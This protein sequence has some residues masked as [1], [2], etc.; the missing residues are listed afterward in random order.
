[1][2]WFLPMQYTVRFDQY[3][4]S[5]AENPQGLVPNGEGQGRLPQN[6]FVRHQTRGFDI[7][8][9]RKGHHAVDR[10]TYPIWSN[11]I[12]CFDKEHAQFDRYV[13]F[14][15][16]SFTWGYAPFDDNFGTVIERLSNTPILQC[17]VP[18][19][20]QRHQYEKFVEIV[21]HIRNLPKAIFVFYFSNDI[22]D[23]YIHPHSTVIDGWLVDTVSVDEND[24]IVRPTDQEL[25]ATLAD[26]LEQL[27]QKEREKISWWGRVKGGLKTYSL[28]VN[29]LSHAKNKVI[30]M[31]YLLTPS[32][33]TTPPIRNFYA[34]GHQEK[35]GTYWY[36]DNPRAQANKTA[37]LSFKRFSTEK[38]IPFVVVLIPHK[39]K[40]TERWY[41][42]LRAFLAENG[43]R[44]V[45]LTIRFRE[46]G[47]TT[48]DVFWVHDGHLNPSGKAATAEILVDEFPQVFKRSGSTSVTAQ[49]EPSRTAR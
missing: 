8:S 6:Y 2:F 19:T 44:Y 17:G 22:I 1:M 35:N 47:L 38:H 14:A 9:N 30:E 31:T 39:Y 29:I 13:Y 5:F 34:L 46:K 27:E 45:D 37:L 42:E 7:G 25:K 36:S 4:L 21:G 28:A 12:G 41:E 23:D 40:A 24:G 15:G 11:S 26:K 49:Q 43:V 3:R 10:S 18:H 16:D 32:K 33:K 20:G 48:S